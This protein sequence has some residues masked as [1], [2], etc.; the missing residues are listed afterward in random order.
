MGLTGGERTGAA[1]TDTA[2]QVNRLHFPVTALGPGRRLGVWTQGCSVRCAGCLAHDTWSPGNGSPL[3]PEDF[4]VLWRRALD[5]GADGLTVSGGEPG[6]QP[7]ALTALLR[8][9][10]EEVAD[11][12]ADLLVYTGHPL[13]VLEQRAPEVTGGLADTVISEPF[14]A[15]LPTALI[16]RGSANQ[17]V[18]PLT[19]LGRERY[20]PWLEHRPERAPMQLVASDSDAWLIGVPRPGELAL[21]ER[22]LRTAGFR[23]GQVSWRPGR[24]F[25]P[26]SAPESGDAPREVRPPIT[27]SGPLQKEND[28]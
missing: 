7:Q 22:A 26:G 20:G 21:L 18:T 23:H 8:V 24:R 13:T 4:R 9:A 27:S 15:D 6:D 25:L 2:L 10:R 11:R 5:Q 14:R 1:P 3:T 28:R 16:W 19:P 17:I 12:P